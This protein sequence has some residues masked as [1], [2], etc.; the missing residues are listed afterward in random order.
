MNMETQE[1]SYESG[2]AIETM[3]N[4]L[5]FFGA[6]SLPDT[7]TFSFAP[8]FHLI[9]QLLTD[10]LFTESGTF[11][12]AIG[13][14]RGHGKTTVI[15]L[16]IVFAILFTKRKLILAVSANEKTAG[17]I[18]SDVCAILD[19]PNIK[20]LFGDWKVNSDIDSRHTKEFNFRGRD[21]A[22]VAAGFNTEVRGL[23]MNNA[24][25]DLM[26]FDDAQTRECALSPEQA[27]E[28]RERLY[29][30]W[31]KLKG[32]SCIQIWIGNMYRD[33][34]DSKG[35]YCCMLRAM[36]LD[37]NW[38]SFITGAILADGQAL[39]PELYSLEALL[40]DLSVDM[41]AGMEDTWF[42]E[43]QNDPEARS[44]KLIDYSKIIKVPT[45]TLQIPE[46][47][48]LII[49]P[50]TDK[51]N[52]DDQIITHV[53]LHSGLPVVRSCTVNNGTP[54]QVITAAINMCIQHN[55]PL[56]CVE[57]VGYQHSLLFWFNEY[58][59]SAHISGITIE[60]IS[61]KGM[62]KNTRILASIKQIVRGEI[63]FAEEAYAPYLNQVQAFDP[64]TDK[65]RDDILDTV[66]YIPQVLAEY[67]HEL[68]S[69]LVADSLLVEEN[70]E[71]T[72]F[73]TN[74]LLGLIH[75]G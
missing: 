59:E 6:V 52:T 7:I 25:P 11:R 50:A 48:C 19:E 46:G 44:I 63:A 14:P 15:K 9:W 21:I 73:S 65:N 38:V 57:N 35:Q 10:A 29:S 5:D 27:Q 75:H 43:I 70:S 31:L 34:K 67:R 37:K 64:T 66:A 49:D 51:V 42:A 60:P 8:L 22:L 16:L 2:N 69:P 45:I 23:N 41:A 33:V 26:V 72:D 4:S 62:K 24:R 18:I 3:R 20:K 68:I 32:P 28:F 58:L 74:N 1:S 13:L 55:I 17:N 40:E 53:E 54:K 47:A 71:L 56:I 39:F 12:Y 61:P 30:T 36:Q